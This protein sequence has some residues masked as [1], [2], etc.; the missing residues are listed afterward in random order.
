MANKKSKENHRL[1][2]V[3]T[4]F[5]DWRKN[6]KGRRDRIPES[7]WDAAASLSG[8]FSVNELSKALR[9]NHSSL[10]ER[11]ETIQNKPL[12]EPCLTTFIE[13]PPL[14]AHADATEVSL[15]LEKTGARMKVHAK[16][17]ID[18]LSLV[19]TFWG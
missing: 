9:L 13:F 3:Q 16:G 8:G 6:R 10:K 1:E 7:L 19:Q 4:Q 15:E 18:V 17:N 11:I 12:E 14:N 5:T 2:T